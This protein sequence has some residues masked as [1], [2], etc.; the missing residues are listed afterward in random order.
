MF[1]NLGTATMRVRQKQIGAS[2][3]ATLVSAA[4]LSAQV[5][6]PQLVSPV[7]QVV[8]DVDPVGI[9]IAVTDS[10]GRSVT[11]LTHRDFVVFED[12]QP[13][14]LRSAELVGMPYSILVLVD[15]SAREEKSDWPKF[16][17][18]SVD[19][20]LKNLRGPD[21]LAVAGF[22]DRVA[23]LLDWRPSR[24]GNVQKVMLKKSSQPTRFFEAIDWASDEMQYVASG[25]TA[26]QP[27]AK[28]RKGVIVFTDGRDRAMYPELQKINGRDVPDPAYRVPASV[29]LRFER[30]RRTLE[31][32]NVPFYFVA[33]DTD[34][35]LSEKSATAKLEGWVRFLREVRG[36]IEL[37]ASASGGH[38]AFPKEIEDLLPLYERIQR[39]LGTGYHITYK[40]LRPPDGQLRRVE[41]QVRN[42]DLKVYQATNSYYPR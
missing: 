22:D 26:A 34:L 21:R 18:K 20:F 11:D 35:Q 15:R 5:A 12:G 31:D 25:G 39:D 42:S 3:V 16:V 32:G 7:Y 30:S 19:L 9:D 29:D 33:M 8:V 6:P 36:R 23:V 4:L 17:L 41:V 1:P 40:S 28:G 2:L 24:N 13:Q 14:E 38:A 37:L 27:F 10:Q